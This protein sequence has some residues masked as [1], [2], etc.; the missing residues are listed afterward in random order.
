MVISE[1]KKKA[2]QEVVQRMKDN[3]SG[4]RKFLNNLS[5]EEL[6]D[7]ALFQNYNTSTEA[8]E[9]FVKVLKIIFNLEIK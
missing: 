1:E 2:L 8:N 6:R 5:N 7:T 4:S 9:D 3:N